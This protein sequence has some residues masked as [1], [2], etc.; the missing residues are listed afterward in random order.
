MADP[1]PTVGELFKAKAVTDDQVNAAVE[2]YLA[3]PATGLVRLA[4][5][6]R[7]DVAE[8]VEAHPFARAT[9]SGENP[10]PSR[11]RKAIRAAILLARA[12]KA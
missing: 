6:C 7:I 1:N 12:Q 5:G 9:L 3:D 11:K 4:N 8:A 2:A 10:T